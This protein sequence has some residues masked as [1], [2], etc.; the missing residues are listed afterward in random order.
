MGEVELYQ[1]SGLIIIHSVFFFYGDAA[2]HDLAF[3]IAQDISTHWNQAQS[4][5]QLRRNSLQVRFE[6]EGIYRPDL[7]PD[8]VW[9]NT[10]PRNNYF[11][12]EEY[13]MNHISFVDG[14]NAIRGISNWI[15]SL[16]IQLRQLTSMDILLAWSILQN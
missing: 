8:Q 3:Q 15:T 12:I 9:Y 14:S 2:S 1:S 16:T 7:L 11:R 6:V 10:N 5:I 4:F 13:A